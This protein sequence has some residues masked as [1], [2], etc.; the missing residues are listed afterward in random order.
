M[1]I[2]DIIIILILLFGLV[3]GWKR[4][5]IR[6]FVS[7]IGFLVVV[8]AS[9]F[10]KNPIGDFL[11]TH[12]MFF[13][14]TGIIKGVTVLNIALYELIAFLFV[15]AILTIILRFV[16]FASATVEGVLNATIIL[17]IPSKI[18]GAIFGVIEYFVLLFIML[19][20]VN[21]PVFANVSD[22]TT[23][24]SKL[25]NQILNNT[26]ILSNVADN[27]LKMSEEFIVLKNKY[28]STNNTNEYNLE[29]L[30]LFLK[31]KVT[32]PETADKLIESKK[33]NITG[34]EKVINQYKEEK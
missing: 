11:C 18:L 15:M 19:Y 20:I 21:L 13:N 25:A 7:C 14:F 12:S 32:T 22:M 31:Y 34:A 2:L 8:V 29:T 4:G 27:T 23:N 17:G 1:H 10:L 9:Y 26:P 3:S 24:N 5:F 16:I 33:L 6:S 28:A 30:N